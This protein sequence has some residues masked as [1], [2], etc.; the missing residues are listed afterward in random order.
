MTEY[1][2]NFIN[3]AFVAFVLAGATVAFGYTVWMVQEFSKGF[4]SV[5]IGMPKAEEIAAWIPYGISGLLIVLLM[6]K[7]GH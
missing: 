4:L 5:F 2:M 7:V 3:Y 6:W 1:L